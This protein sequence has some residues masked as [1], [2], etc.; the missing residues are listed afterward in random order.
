MMKLNHS[1][2]LEKKSSD[3]KSFFRICGKKS[4]FAF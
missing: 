1:I 4:I 3:S 2:V